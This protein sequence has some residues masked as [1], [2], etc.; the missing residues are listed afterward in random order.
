M[1]TKRSSFDVAKPVCAVHCLPHH[2]SFA[3][4]KIIQHTNSNAFVRIELS[5]RSLNSINQTESREWNRIRACSWNRISSSI[6]RQCA[7]LAM[8]LHHTL[9]KSFLESIEKGL[10]WLVKSRLCKRFVIFFFHP[11]NWIVN[12][13]VGFLLR[14]V[15]CKNA[16]SSFDLKCSKCGREQKNAAIFLSA[17]LW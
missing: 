9:R 15:R 16:R 13:I 8:H 11:Y 12:C 4:V 7:W 17:H 2:V 1:T 3:P 5:N 6:T 10:Q 14:L